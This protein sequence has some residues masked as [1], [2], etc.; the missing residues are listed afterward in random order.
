MR[1]FSIITA[2][3]FFGCS[4]GMFAQ[5]TVTVT[6]SDAKGIGAENGVMRRDPSDIIKVGNFYYVWYSKGA[7]FSGYDAT[8]WYA[9]S[10]DGHEWSEKGMALAKGEPGN[11][12]AASV[13]TPNILVAEGK[14][15]L[16]YTAISKPS[17]KHSVRTR[18]SAS[19]YR[20]RPTAH[21]SDSPATRS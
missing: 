3:L 4:S 11:W 21:G 15:W 13:F 19:R 7:I 14:Y 5:D 10:T 9:T 8:I 16:F 12:D 2:I 20:I 18:K 17:I 1:C 6:R